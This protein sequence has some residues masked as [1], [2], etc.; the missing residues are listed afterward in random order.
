MRPV[1]TDRLKEGDAGVKMKKS[2][3]TTVNVKTARRLSHTTKQLVLLIIAFFILYPLFFMLFS[4]VK[5]NWDIIEK[6]FSITGFEITNYKEAW[7]RGK[8]AS[9]FMN[10]VKV[11]AMTLALQLVIIVLGSYAFGKLKPWGGGLIF[12]TCLVAMFVTSEM[13]TIPNY[14]T[15]R[16]MGL[17]D[18]YGG[19]VVP[20]T[21]S[22]LVMGTYILTNFV[23]GLPKE[24]DEAAIIDGAGLFRIMINV[25]LPMIAPAIV[26][27]LIYNFTGVW[28]E[29]YWALITTRSEAIKTMPIGLLAFQS[30]YTSNYGVLMAGLCIMTV[31]GIIVYLLAS[32]Y[33]IAGIK[34]GAIKG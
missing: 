19:L 21:A 27:I 25:D 29:L 34:A 11:T 15:I 23:R 30:Q 17:I 9:Y 31:P 16:S 5:N 14:M 6:P 33:F 2:R 26:T 12:S 1:T 7:V 3:K 8:V 32:K 10:S 18:T 22:G 4:S 13:T 20:Y 28:S 24:L